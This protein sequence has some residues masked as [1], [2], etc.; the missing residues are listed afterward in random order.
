LPDK[1]DPLHAAYFNDSHPGHQAAVE[2]VRARFVAVHGGGER[3]RDDELEHPGP[4]DSRA[5]FA[6]Q[7]PDP[8]TPLPPD[9]LRAV[10]NA[11]HPI[12]G[13]RQDL[14]QQALDYLE[15]GP[16]DRLPELPAN[17]TPPDPSATLAELRRGWGAAAEQNLQLARAVIKAYD[18]QKGGAVS[19][20]LN[21]TGAG[22]DPRLIRLAVRT[23]RQWIK[24]GWRP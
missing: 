15:G 11:L 5:P 2:A 16:S 12:A 21:R 7:T 14:V 22:N 10:A 9:T 18:A 20:F 8:R 1:S 13:G 19:E 6:L 23:A 17:Y 24:A 4:A 3:W